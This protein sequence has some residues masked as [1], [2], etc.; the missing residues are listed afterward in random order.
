MVSKFFK[1][2]RV[3]LNFVEIRGLGSFE[4]PFERVNLAPKDL[5][6]FGLRPEE[7]QTSDGFASRVGHSKCSSFGCARC[8]GGCPRPSFAKFLCRFRVDFTSFH[9]TSLRFGLILFS[10]AS[11]DAH[12]FGSAGPR[13]FSR[14]QRGACNGRMFIKMNS[15]RSRNGPMD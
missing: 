4:R 11:H 2:R 7:L 5:L 8:R 10:L 14:D 13:R 15:I 9:L 6:R 3:L 1:F 12:D